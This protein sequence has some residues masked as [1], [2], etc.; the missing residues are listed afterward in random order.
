MLSEMVC[1]VTR[2]KLR[3]TSGGTIAK[4]A[5]TIQFDAELLP[6]AIAARHTRSTQVAKSCVFFV[7][8]YMTPSVG[9]AGIGPLFRMGRCSAWA[10][11][12]AADFCT[13]EVLTLAGRARHS[14]V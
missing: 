2:Q 9:N 5:T 1:A 8:E 7:S 4:Q 10:H 13:V 11:L 12:G 14:V 6:S 3:A